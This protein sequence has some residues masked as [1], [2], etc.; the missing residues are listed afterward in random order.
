M[1][2][3]ASKMIEKQALPSYQ[4]QNNSRSQDGL[5]GLRTARGDRERLMFVTDARSKLRTAVMMKEGL[6]LGIL[7]GLALAFL[8][9]KAGVLQV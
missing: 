9:V 6:V 1:A 7:L 8:L 2:S 4:A 3:W 5:P